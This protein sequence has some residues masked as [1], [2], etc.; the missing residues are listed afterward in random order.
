MGSAGRRLGFAF[1]VTFAV[2]GALEGVCRLIEL[3]AAPSAT[4][5]LPPP[6]PLHGTP[7]LTANLRER[8]ANEP[9]RVALQPD[10][11]LGWMPAPSELLSAE[12]PNA[13]H[14]LGLRSP[15]PDPLVSGEVRLLALGDSS[16]W[17]TGVNLGQTFTAVAARG[18]Q[19]AWR[20][21]VTG[22]V[23]GI[24]G[25]N[26]QQSRLLLERVGERVAPSWLVVANMWSDLG[27]RQ[28]VDTAAPSPMAAQ[29]DHLAIFR[30]TSRLLAPWLR[31]RR[32]RFLAGRADIGTPEESRSTQAGYLADLRAM[33]DW[34][35][36]HH[37]RVLFLMLP[38]P[39]DWDVA[40]PPDQL[41]TFRDCMRLVAEERHGVLVDGPAWFKAHGADTSYFLDQVHPDD[42]GHY[43][44]G[45]AIAAAITK[46]G[47]PPEGASGYGG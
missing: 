2:L 31:V 27:R 9:I 43:L 42:R 3:G 26:S 4:Q 24:P 37:A 36:A 1:V 17:G 7:Q 22:V 16:I 40:P 38:A 46:A 32:V 35:S 20:R 44:L 15:D 33:A 21:P 39:I 18:L 6:D 5:T 34:A 12:Q 19:T 29:L 14:T 30:Q 10:P 23:G 13:A 11:E 8:Q 47:P 45:E 25:Y 41:L 28:L